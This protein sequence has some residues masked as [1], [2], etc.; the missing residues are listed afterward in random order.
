MYKNSSSSR[1]QEKIQNAEL[2]KTLSEEKNVVNK[3]Y[4]SLLADI[5]N[6]MD[7]TEKRVVEQNMAMFKKTCEDQSIVELQKIRIMVLKK[8]VS[9]ES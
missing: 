8:M 6:F 3:K 1:I 2:L 4:N 5:K 9:I 7:S